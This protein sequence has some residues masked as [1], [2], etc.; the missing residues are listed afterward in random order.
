MKISNISIDETFN[1]AGDLLGL[2]NPSFDI[3]RDNYTFSRH[4]TALSL[5]FPIKKT[6]NIGL[7]ILKAKDNIQS[8]YAEVPGAIIEIP[9]AL[10]DFIREDS[11]SYLHSTETIMIEETIVCEGLETDPEECSEIEIGE[12]IISLGYDHNK[13]GCLKTYNHGKRNVFPN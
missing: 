2:D 4:L 12:E 10:N 7:N 6:M 3:G 11:E 5:N 8:V 1:E 9:S 13:G